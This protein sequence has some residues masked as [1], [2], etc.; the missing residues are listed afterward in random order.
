LLESGG[1]FR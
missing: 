1:R